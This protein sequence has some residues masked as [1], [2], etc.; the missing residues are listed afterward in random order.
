MQRKTLNSKGMVGEYAPVA[1][2]VQSFQISDD[3]RHI[4]EDQKVSVS[5]RPSEFKRMECKKY[6]SVEDSKMDAIDEQEDENEDEREDE[7]SPKSNFSPSEFG[8]DSPE[9]SVSK[10]PNFPN[11]FLQ[12]PDVVVKTERKGYQTVTR[13][14]LEEA[15]IESHQSTSKDISENP[16]DAQ[17]QSLT[18]WNETDQG[19]PNSEFAGLSK[20]SS[21]GK[22]QPPTSLGSLARDLTPHSS[23]FKKKLAFRAPEIPWLP[24]HSKKN[25]V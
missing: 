1:N 19:T 24:V 23:N 22:S 16:P 17:K 18:I 11:N 12:I 5:I 10:T 14:I 25:Q 4:S 8:E 13:V 20:P 15:E 3:P 7:Q 6:L 2:L 21:H 9:R